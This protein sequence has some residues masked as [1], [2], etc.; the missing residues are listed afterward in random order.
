MPDPS[1]EV[2]LAAVEPIFR[3]PLFD[4][5]SIALKINKAFGYLRISG[6]K[7]LSYE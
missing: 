1:P 2:M 3:N 5:L 4:C 6:C 7:Q